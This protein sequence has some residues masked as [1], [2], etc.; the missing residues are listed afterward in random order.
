MNPQ[1]QSKRRSEHIEARWPGDE[2]EDVTSRRLVLLDLSVFFERRLL[3]FISDLHIGLM[4]VAYFA[5]MCRRL[6]CQRLVVMY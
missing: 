2:L 5:R 4:I 6:A 1:K 3:C